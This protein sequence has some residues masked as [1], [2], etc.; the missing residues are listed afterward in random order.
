MD[1]EGEKW[2]DPGL[3]LSWTITDTEVNNTWHYMYAFDNTNGKNISHFILETSPNFTVNDIFNVKVG[4]EAFTDYLIDT[5]GDEGGSN[6]EIPELVYG[7]KFNSAGLVYEFDTHRLPVWGD[8]YTKDGG[9]YRAFDQGFGS[10]D[11]D[12]TG[13]PAN[14]TL[15]DNILR[16]DSVAPGLPA[17][18]LVGAAP[19]LGAWLRRRKR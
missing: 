8:F 1:V 10:P 18:A 3:T 16:P 15:D 14:G 17:I 2:L 11:V 7:I 12:P 9:G 5:W 13:P 4:G 6:P 19:L